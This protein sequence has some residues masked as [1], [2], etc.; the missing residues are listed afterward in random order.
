MVLG[1]AH[2]TQFCAEEEL[3]YVQVEHGHFFSEFESSVMELESAEFLEV[4]GTSDKADED[5]AAMTTAGKTLFYPILPPPEKWKFQKTPACV[6]AA[7]FLSRALSRLQKKVRE[8]R[9]DF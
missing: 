2:M 4:E 6:R 8:N 7:D 5:S 3:R 9:R 1:V